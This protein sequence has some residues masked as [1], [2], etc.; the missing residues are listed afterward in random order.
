MFCHGN[1]REIILYSNRYKLSFYE[2]SKKVFVRN[3]Y[4]DCVSHFIFQRIL[5]HILSADRLAISRPVFRRQCLGKCS[6][7]RFNI[8]RGVAFFL[9]QRAEERR[10]QAR[11]LSEQRIT[12]SKFLVEKNIRHRFGISICVIGYFGELYLNEPILTEER[13]ASDYKE[14]SS[15]VDT[16]LESGYK[17]KVLTHWKNMNSFIEEYNKTVTP[18]HDDAVKSVIQRIKELSSFVE[19]DGNGEKP[20]PLNYII[21]KQLSRDIGYLLQH[22]LDYDYRFD[23]NQFSHIAPEGNKWKLSINTVFAESDNRDELQK[24]RLIIKAVV[25]DT[26][27][28]ERLGE[29]RQCRKDAESE[30][31]SFRRELTKTIKLVENG[32]PLEGECEICKGFSKK[33]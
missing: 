8:G 16:H 9:G 27:I 13:E 7:H 11:H 4:S 5:N 6:S 33:S 25:T 2:A 23:I 1:F 19:F 29:L 28:I 3:S 18:I 14:Y 31:Q 21:P 32:I 22:C 26:N 20:K 24:I 10:E 12:H 15:N 30:L 17:E